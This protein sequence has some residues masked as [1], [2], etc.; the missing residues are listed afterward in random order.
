MSIG[1][2][3][4]LLPWSVA[5]PQEATP[6][7]IKAYMTKLYGF[8]SGRIDEVIELFS[9]RE[10]AE[11]ALRVATEDAPERADG[12]FIEEIEIDEPSLN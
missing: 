3:A 10:K 5:G 9:T 6:D 11:E 2:S 4:Y 1:R 7:G 12:A 8:A